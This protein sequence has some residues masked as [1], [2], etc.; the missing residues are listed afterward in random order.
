MIWG[1]YAVIN[2]VGIGISRTI[3]I[4]NTM[5]IMASRKNRIENGIRAV[6]FGSN[7]HSNGVDFSRSSVDRAAK[8]LA[9]NNTTVGI[10]MQMINIEVA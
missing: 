5:K 6:F 3:S 8:M 9:A 7:P 1:A 2:I 10:N 4:S